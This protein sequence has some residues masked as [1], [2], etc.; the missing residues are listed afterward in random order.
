[1]CGRYKR[2]SDKQQIAEFF[3]VNGEI[4]ELPILPEDDIR[5]TMVQPVIRENR[6]TGARD[7]VTARWGFVPGWHK[8]GTR[9]PPTTFNA[10]AEEIASSG[11]W[12][13]AFATHRCLVPADSFFEWRKIRPKN[14]PKF[15][16]A[17]GDARPFAFAGLWGA[18]KNPETG[19]WLQSYTIITTDPNELMETIHT[20]MPVILHPKDYDRWL[21]R[22]A[23]EQLP[24]DLLRP[25]EAEQM[26]AVPV[27]NQH[28]EIFSEPNSA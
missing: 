6:D 24:V 18:W 22:E 15:E 10:R 19:D 12:K 21:S 20:R 3:H 13:R 1:M 7:L 25:Y 17:L 5:P 11:M 4:T 9:L 27:G 2:T 28:S 14:N 16:I 26:V 8:P 23:R